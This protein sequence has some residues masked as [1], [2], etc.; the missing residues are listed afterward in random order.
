MRYFI[1]IVSYLKRYWA[2]VVLNILCNILSVLF[3]LVSLTMIIPFLQLLFSQHT[4]GTDDILPLPVFTFRAQYFIDLFNYFFLKIIVHKGKLEALAFVC[5]MVVIIFFFKNL[6]RYAALYSLAPIRHGVVRDLRHE[7]FDKLL[8]L[9]LSYYS[10]KKKGDML[11]RMTAD[12]SEIEYGIISM[13]EITF[14]EPI[15]IVAYLG[16]MIYMSHSLTFFVLLMLIITGFIVGRIGRSLKRTSLKGQ[17]KLGELMQIIEES[18]S[19]LRII[20]AFNAEAFQRE[21]FERENSQYLKLMTRMQ[22]RKDLSSPLSEFLA[23]GIVAIVLWFGGRLVL[24]TDADLA[25]ETFIG[26]MVIFSQLIPPAK[27][28]SSAY[29]NI[30][31]GLASSE[32]VFKMLDSVNPIREKIG[33]RPINTFKNEIE[34]RNVSFRYNQYDNKEVLKN[35]NLRIAKGRMI[36]IVGQSGSGKSTLVNLLPRFYDVTDGQILID[37]TDIR[38]YRLK[39]L[40]RLFGVVSQEPILFNDTVFNNIALGQKNVSRSEIERAAKIAN[41]HEFI[42]K[43]EQG[44]DTCIGDRGNKLSGGEKQRLTIARAVL[45]DPPV[46]IMDEATSSLDAESEKLVQ[47]ALH[48]LM[49]HRTV[50]VIAHRLATIQFADEIIVMQNGEII[51][52]GN[53]IGLMSKNGVYR[54]LVEMQQF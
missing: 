17:D 26:F 39:D 36:A 35:I 11:T 46:L 1:R 24:E 37:G 5:V 42:L 29:Y 51:E 41:A 30:Q 27:S 9:P 53:H 45:S 3:S 32:R 21:R 12:I 54:K 10:E 22:R 34:F 28:F 15:T 13:L 33:A 40:R 14:R 43:L 31:K 49:Q 38:D 19:G 4:T 52:R 16:A 23:I 50:I 6:F 25:P 18:L 2:Y 47:D 7:L 20:Q 44:Y 8:S 48:R